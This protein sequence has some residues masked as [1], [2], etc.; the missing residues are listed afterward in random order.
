MS[1]AVQEM[2]SDI[3]ARYDAANTALSFG[4]HH[5][6]RKK[7]VS[8]LKLSGKE[9]VLDICCGTGDL[10]FEAAPKLNCDGQI[11]GLDF[12][13]PMLERAAKKAEAKNLP[14][15][16]VQADALCL[17]LPDNFADV[18]MIAFGIRN[19]D[20]P[21]HFLH[22]ARRVLVPGGKILVLEFGQVTLPVLRSFYSFYAKYLMPEI[23]GALTGNRAAYRYL[24]ETS[25]TFP[26][27]KKFLSLLSSSGYQ[28]LEQKKF[29]SGIAY[30]YLGHNP[31][32]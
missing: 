16:F 32:E 2:F 7:A 25:R 3:A 15:L 28:H 10:G 18:V 9:I 26:A 8:M 13:W 24:P 6:W 23:G 31:K 5:W 21:E 20:S 12:S 30:A 19:V 22:E 11:F 14:G 1:Q 17:P 4:I 27:G 29:L